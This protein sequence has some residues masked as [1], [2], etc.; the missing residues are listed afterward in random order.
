MKMFKY[1]ISALFLCVVFLF[2]SARSAFCADISGLKAGY[3]KIFRPSPA[4]KFRKEIRAARKALVTGK[5][6]EAIE[7]YREI[8][9]KSG[10]EDSGLLSEY[11][12]ALALGGFPEYSVINLDR[13]RFVDLRDIRVFYYAARIFEKS[14]INGFSPELWPKEL[15]KKMP[16]W[17]RAETGRINDAYA[18]RSFDFV[19][20]GNLSEEM[21]K[22]NLL[23]GNQCYFQAVYAFEGITRKFPGEY[24]PY[25]GYAIALDRIGLPDNASGKLKKALE[26]LR[27]KSGDAVTNINNELT[28][29]SVR[30]KQRTPEEKK[31][32]ALLGL[33]SPYERNLF[34]LGASAGSSSSLNM[35]LGAYTG[36]SGEAGVDLGYYSPGGINISLSA[37]HQLNEKYFI[38]TGIRVSPSFGL[39]GTVGRKL[40]IGR[41]ISA[42]LFADI[43]LGGSGLKVYL[44]LGQTMYWGKK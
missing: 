23:L 24:L 40:A 8:M 6:F 2:V 4:K 43:E 31:D 33:K 37:R 11:A 15:N 27:G 28:V 12:Y 21:D 41:K 5:S 16:G 17:L 36:K 14:G 29:L 18:S 9:D 34:F 32:A 35:R 22:A 19:P 25:A 26:L 13:A 7:K 44:N 20:E 39:I 10:A 30:A 38:G 42:D 3:E 1:R